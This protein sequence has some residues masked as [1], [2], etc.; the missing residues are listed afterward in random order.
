MF[1]VVVF[2]FHIQHFNIQLFH[3][4]LATFRC[5]TCMLVFFVYLTLNF[6]FAAVVFKFY[7]QHFDMQHLTFTVF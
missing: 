6:V 3:M 2:K 4:Q 5:S 1:A 7:I